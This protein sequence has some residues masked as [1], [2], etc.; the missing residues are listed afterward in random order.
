MIFICACVFCNVSFAE[1]LSLDTALQNTYR[2]CVG[3]Y[4]DLHDMKVL[5]GINT[6]VTGVGTGLGVGAVATGI[7]KYRTDK[8]IA[9]IEAMLNEIKEKTKNNPVPEFT[10]DDM[11]QL[12]DD[13][14]KSYQDMIDTKNHQET[15]ITELDKKSKQ[16]GKWRTGLLAGNTATNIAGVIIANKNKTDFDL[17]EKIARCIVSVNDLNNSILASKI[18][19]EDITEAQLIFDNCRQYEFIDLSPIN[20]R[21]KGAMVSSAVGTVAGGIGTITSAIAN[22]DVTRN[23]D[24]ETGKQKEKNLNTAANVLSAG[25]TMASATATV[26]NAAQIAAIKKVAAVAENCTRVLK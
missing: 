17:Q 10:Q 5:A 20:N 9:D 1:T 21:A 4:D 12:S 8:T 18:S 24:S 22:S 2:A 16:L 6:V 14:E 13:F 25:S 23:D 26:F 15:Q 3:I 7:A 19:G 11:Q